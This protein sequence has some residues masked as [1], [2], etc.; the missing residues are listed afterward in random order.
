M[1]AQRK[2][3]WTEESYLAFERASDI[4]HEYVHGEVYAMAGASVKHNFITQ[5]IA[6]SLHSQLRGKPCAATTSDMRVKTPTRMYSYPDV[7]IICGKP[8][9]DDSQYVD[10]LLNPTLIVEV[11]SPSTEAFDRGK[12]FTHYQSMPSLQEYLLVAQDEA[13]V[14]HLRRQAD[15]KWLLESYIHLTDSLLLPS[16]DCTLALADVYDKVVLD[17]VD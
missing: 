14:E 2:P 9:L 13:R 16:I 17:S 15:G 10:T 5:N 1:V 3:I 6:S 11:L 8:E 7:V 12:K 4:R